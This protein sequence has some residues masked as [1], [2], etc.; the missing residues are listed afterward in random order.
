MKAIQ[1]SF[2]IPNKIRKLAIIKKQSNCKLSHKHEGNFFILETY[3][4][5]SL[6]NIISFFRDPSTIGLLGN[7]KDQLNKFILELQKN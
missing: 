4:K 6:G 5:V 3:N 7:K 1:F 2:Q